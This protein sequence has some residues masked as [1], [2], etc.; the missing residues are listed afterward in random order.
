M[1][2]FVLLWAYNIAGQRGSLPQGQ[3]SSGQGPIEFPGF[4]HIPQ[5]QQQALIQAVARA[6]AQYRLVYVAARP[7]ASDW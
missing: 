4:G 6:A 3:A 5:G 2:V 7:G 1:V